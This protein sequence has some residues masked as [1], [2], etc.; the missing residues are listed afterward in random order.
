MKV[1]GK[2]IKVLHSSGM[3]LALHEGI[4]LGCNG[5]P[6]T[7]LSSLFVLS[8]SGEEENFYEFNNLRCGREKL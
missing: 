8:V 5:L 3:F 2:V 7:K 4:R 1:L 6:G